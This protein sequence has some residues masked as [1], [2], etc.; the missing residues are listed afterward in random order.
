M[1]QLRQQ[2][3]FCVFSVAPVIELYNYFSID[4]FILTNQDI[5]ILTLVYD[6]LKVY[7]LCKVGSGCAETLV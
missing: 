1:A 3:R 7:F 2:F 6:L 4:D 5:S